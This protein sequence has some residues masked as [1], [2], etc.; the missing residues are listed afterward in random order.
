MF[1]ADYFSSSWFLVTDLGG[2]VCKI[3]AQ[4]KIYALTHNKSYPQ[5]IVASDKIVPL[6]IL[7]KG[8]NDEAEHDDSSEARAIGGVADAVPQCRTGGAEAHS[9]WIC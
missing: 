6:S 5:E 1:Q 8:R 2:L 4:V 9:D 7:V 3:G